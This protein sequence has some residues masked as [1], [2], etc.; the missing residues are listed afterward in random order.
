MRIRASRFDV[1]RKPQ[2]LLCRTALVLLPLI[3]KI[4][5]RNKT[6]AVGSTTNSSTTFDEGGGVVVWEGGLLLPAKH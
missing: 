6:I 1:E 3:Q 5:T 2:L 4:L